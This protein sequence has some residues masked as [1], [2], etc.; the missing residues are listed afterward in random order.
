M[1]AAGKPAGID[2][3]D[4][5]LFC[6]EIYGLKGSIDVERIFLVEPASIRIVLLYEIKMPDYVESSTLDHLGHI[7]PIAL[8]DFCVIAFRRPGANLMGKLFLGFVNRKKCFARGRDV[9]DRA[10]TEVEVENPIRGFIRHRY[11]RCIV[12]LEA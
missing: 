8:P 3:C 11:A 1:F 12:R 7:L 9:V 2:L 6:C 4:E 5:P 10:D